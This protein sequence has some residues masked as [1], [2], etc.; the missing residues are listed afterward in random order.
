M[1]AHK[2]GTTQ[3]C[4]NIGNAYVNAFT[5][6]KVYTVAGKE[7]GET[8][9][10]SIIIIRK[11]LLYRLRTSSEHWYSHFAG[12]LRGIGFAPTRYDNGMWIR[13]N[14]DG[15][16][17]D[18]ICTHVD[19]F[20]IVGTDPTAIMDMIHAIYAVKSIGPPDYYYLLGNDYKKD[21]EGRWCSIRCKKYRVEAIKRVKRMFG[22]LKIH[23]HPMVTGD[24]PE[25]DE[26]EMMDDEGHR[27]Y[28]M[29]MGMLRNYLPSSPKSGR[30]PP[31]VKSADMA[32]LL[33]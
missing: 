30:N 20:M 12:S 32:I 28:Q 26:S 33:V 7:F 3:L 11:A 29:F 13:L 5:N 24:H 19:D 22:V 17:Y 1:I 21:K 2:T 9:E 8:V 15:I 31:T 4:G 27:K 25:L 6:E 16:C 14:K 10:G 23:S 18:Y